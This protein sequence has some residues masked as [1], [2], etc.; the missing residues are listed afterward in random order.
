MMDWK[1]EAVDKLRCY[2]AK[3]TSLSTM[4]EELRR[5]DDAMTGIRSATS[6]STPVSGGSST[7]EDAMINN[8]ANREELRR[9][10]RDA[11]RWV[12]MVDAALAVLDDEERLVLD[13]FYIHRQKGNVDRL[14]E[15]MHVE[16]AQVY[17][18]KDNAVRHFTIALYGNIET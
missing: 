1:R 8:I 11:V 18:R 10:R 13:R 2:E 6:D 16:K 12:R 7:R 17:R 9:A 14:C 4:E 3:R 15:D 5:L